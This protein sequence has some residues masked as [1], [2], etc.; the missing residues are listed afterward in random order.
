MQTSSQP[1]LTFAIL[2]IHFLPPQTS[3]AR[4]IWPV[5][6]Q[7]TKSFRVLEAP[8]ISTLKMNPCKPRPFFSSFPF[9]VRSVMRLIRHS[10]LLISIFSLFLFSFFLFFLPYIFHVSNL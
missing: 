10:F 8:G 6:H 1:Y 5:L 7:L 9:P 3:S 2:D 4:Q